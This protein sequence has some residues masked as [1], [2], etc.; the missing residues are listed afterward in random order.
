MINYFSHLIVFYQK[1]KKCYLSLKTTQNRVIKA[2]IYLE[3]D[4]F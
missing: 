1:R 4:N 2:E 3:I